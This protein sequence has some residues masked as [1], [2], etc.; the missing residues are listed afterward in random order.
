MAT[1]RTKLPRLD[2]IHPG[3]PLTGKHWNE[4]GEKFNNMALLLERTSSGSLSVIVARKVDAQSSAPSSGASASGITVA[5]SDL[6][7]IYNGIKEINFDLTAFQISFVGA[8]TVRIDPLYRSDSITYAASGAQTVTFNVN[9]IA[10]P[11]AD[12]KYS[13]IAVVT[14]PD[15]SMS[16]AQVSARTAAGFNVQTYE[17]GAIVDYKA[18]YQT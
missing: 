8:G 16:F 4:L 11:F 14:S 9:G 3:E 2:N 17:N 5:A 18:T 13:L 7:A 12:T 6:S 10:S 1:N 15:G